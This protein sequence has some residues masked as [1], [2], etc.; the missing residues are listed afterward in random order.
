MTSSSCFQ[1]CCTEDELDPDGLCCYEGNS[2]VEITLQRDYLLLRLQ[3]LVDSETSH[4]AERAI[5]AMDEACGGSRSGTSNDDRAAG[6]LRFM[7]R[8][9]TIPILHDVL[10]REGK[11]SR[12]SPVVAAPL[13]TRLSIHEASMKK[14]KHLR[15]RSCWGWQCYNENE[16][17]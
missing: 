5:R 6:L 7:V 12:P 4:E 17:S 8:A 11:E 2:I 13:L 10:A 15:E 3:E 1:Y 9:G 14:E 16:D